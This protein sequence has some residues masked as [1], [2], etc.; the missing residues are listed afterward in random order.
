MQVEI[1]LSRLHTNS[2][3]FELRL[4]ANGIKH[5]H[6]QCIDPVPR[7]QVLTAPVHGGVRLSAAQGVRWLNGHHDCAAFAGH[8]H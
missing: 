1:Q 5:R 7:R 3:V 6:S 8:V 4:L 2:S